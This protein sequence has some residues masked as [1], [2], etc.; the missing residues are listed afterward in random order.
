MK[1]AYHTIRE[2]ENYTLPPPPCY[3][4]SAERHHLFIYL[5]IFSLPL[6]TLKMCLPITFLY[7]AKGR[8]FIMTNLMF[9]QNLSTF[10]YF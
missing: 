10:S 3:L 4:S 6:L 9:G 5:F 7:G 1:L 8:R 2:L